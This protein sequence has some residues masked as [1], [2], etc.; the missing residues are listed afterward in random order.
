MLRD[1]SLCLKMFWEW[2][3]SIVRG[4][5]VIVLLLVKGGSDSYVL[6]FAQS[7]G[8]ACIMVSFI[9]SQRLTEVGIG[10]SRMKRKE[11]ILMVGV[12]TSAIRLKLFPLCSNLG[13]SYVNIYWGYRL[14]N[15]FGTCSPP[16]DWALR[17]FITLLG[18]GASRRFLYQIIEA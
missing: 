7:K 17:R 13:G 12:W 1:L 2:H 9:A 11:H 6:A 3:L 4:D 14:H 5:V 8:I 10:G 16:S 18:P 15:G